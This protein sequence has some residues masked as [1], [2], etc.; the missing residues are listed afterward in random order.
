[1]SVSGAEVASRSGK[2]PPRAKL[3]GAT[4]FSPGHRPGK[5]P[6]IPPSP[7]WA[8]QI[9]IPDPPSRRHK[10]RTPIGHGSP[11]S[12]QNGAREVTFLQ[13]AREGHEVGQRNW[14]RLLPSRTLR[15]TGRC[16]STVRNWI[17]L[18]KPGLEFPLRGGQ[19]AG[20]DAG[21]VNHPETGLTVR[22]LDPTTLAAT[23]GRPT[24]WKLD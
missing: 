19:D 23:P 15:G 6:H 24:V 3:K 8:T 21:Q 1:M 9:P 10:G 18:V 5:P 11:H 4:Q 17:N 16:R 7:E 2:P 12:P 20:R 14:T 13:E 22:K